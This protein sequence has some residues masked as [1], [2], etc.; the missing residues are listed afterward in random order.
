[1]IDKLVPEKDSFKLTLR[2][3]KL[4]A[5]SRG[6]YSNVLGYIGG[7]T[8]AML[9][10]K[11]CI[12]NPNTPVNKLLSIFFQFYSTYDWG[13]Q[14]PVALTTILNDPKH[15]EFEIEKDLFKDWTDAKMPIITP[16]FPNS[17]SSFNISD[18]TKEVLLTEF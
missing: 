6:I 16:S 10:A 15:V 11:V 1:M 2:C 17:N 9:V 7:V 5:K 13:P 18:S 12:A 3:I 8:W 4:W 14:N